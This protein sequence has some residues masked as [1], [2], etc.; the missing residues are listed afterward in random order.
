MKCHEGIQ[1]SRTLNQFLY[2]NIDEN[3]QFL[4]KTWGNPQGIPVIC[5][6]GWLDNACSFDA[7]A[8]LLPNDSHK[9]IAIELP[10]HGFSSHFPEGL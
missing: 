1:N 6:H 8:P 9:F 10:G 5:L 2:S 3:F 4:G 7:L